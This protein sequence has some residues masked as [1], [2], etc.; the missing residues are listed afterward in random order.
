MST[1]LPTFRLALQTF[2]SSPSNLQILRTIPASP[3]PPPPKTLYILDSSFNPPHL[4]HFRIAASAFDSSDSSTPSKRL[5][6]L[7]A[8]QNAD[9]EHKPAALGHRLAMMTIFAEDLLKSLS[10]GGKEE[11]SIA[12]DIG[13][14][15]LP[16]FIDKCAAITSS[17]IHKPNP[18]QTGEAPIEQVHLIGYDTLIRL[19][20]T[21]Y[22]PPHHTLAPLQGLFQHHRLRVT[23]RQADNF[24]SR[25]EQDAYLRSLKEGKMED[26]G[27][28]REWAD[29]IAMVAGK[30][31]GDQAISST[32]V[33]KAVEEGDE[34]LVG[35]LCT[36]GVA[37]Y[38]L[39]E[40]VYPKEEEG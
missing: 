10:K 22:Y 17:G 37:R 5:L 35:E 26:K 19:L 16:Y 25:E 3:S 6:L 12:V 21:K 23:Y 1:L 24:G 4:A 39:E 9:K 30:Q 7:L 36:E 38:I 20:D 14:T 2:A 32:R 40:G 11:G 34:G 31:A 28:R 29:K 8:T 33:R 18:P 13:I 15:K 27:G